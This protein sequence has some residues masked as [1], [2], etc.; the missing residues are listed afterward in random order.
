VLADIK[1][2]EKLRPISVVLLT[3]S[4]RDEDVMEALKLKMNYYLAKPVTAAKVSVL[5]KAII[6]LQSEEKQVAGGKRGD[7][8]T[9]VRMVLAGNPHTAP[10]ILRKLAEDENV[11]VRSRV[12][13]NPDTPE[14]V[15]LKLAK[16]DHTDVRIG[17]S[18]NSKVSMAVI[19][20]LSKDSSEDVRMGLAGNPN[21]PVHVLERLI[22]DENTFVAAEA[23]KTMQQVTTGVKS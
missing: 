2:D 23:Q 22:A 18:E 4:Q 19:D 12:A 21:M 20:L 11:R 14:D 7:D 6:E 5:I 15:L 1:A 16:D 9:H 10:S 13:E 17:V 3:V 8:E